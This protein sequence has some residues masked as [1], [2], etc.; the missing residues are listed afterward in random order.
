VSRDSRRMLWISL[1]GF[2]YIEVDLFRSRWVDFM[3][4]AFQADRSPSLMTHGF[5]SCIAF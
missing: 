3:D 4:F 1:I 2:G 5:V